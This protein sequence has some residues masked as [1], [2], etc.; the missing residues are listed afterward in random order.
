MGK[1]RSKGVTI[2]AW[3]MIITNAYA[4]LSSFKFKAN[5]FDV[6]RSLPVAFNVTLIAYSIISAAIAVIAGTGILK[7]KEKMRVLGVAINAIDLFFGLAVLSVTLNDIREYTYSI[8]ASVS[9]TDPSIPVYA[10]A[11][12]SFYATVLLMLFAYGFN[13]LLI[14]F[15][16]RPKVK[17]QFK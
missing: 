3:L 16:T 11:S 8:A 4:L 12:A 7:L 6:Y 10:L 17:E 9:A 15:F 5:F 14:F 1:K 13:L 2:F